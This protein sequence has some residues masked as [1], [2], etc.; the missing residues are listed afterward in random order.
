MYFLGIVAAFPHGDDFPGRSPC[1]DKSRG[2]PSGHGLPPS[3]SPQTFLLLAPMAA[4]PCY[5]TGGLFKNCTITVRP[6]QLSFLKR[7]PPPQSCG[8]VGGSPRGLRKRNPHFS[9]WGLHRCH[10]RYQ[11]F[12]FPN[13]CYFPPAPPQMLFLTHPSHS[14]FAADISL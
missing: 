3:T 11:C 5:G 14:A 12:P 9:M 8:G 10:H 4:I 1:Q 13:T 2:I 7:P 6:Q